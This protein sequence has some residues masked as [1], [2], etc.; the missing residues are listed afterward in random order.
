MAFI[1]CRI[2]KIFVEDN[3]EEVSFVSLSQ[4]SGFTPKALEKSKLETQKSAY[5]KSA[6][7]YKILAPK[8]GKIHLNTQLTKGMVLQA[9]NLLGSMA[10]TDEP[11]IIETL[12]SSDERP[13][14]H[15]GDE[16]SIAVAG[17][18]QAEYGTVEGQVEGIYGDATKIIRKGIYILKLG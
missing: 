3:I 1:Y 18:N 14:I 17:L 2:Y 4:S 8:S 11:L 9:G 7:E 16:V 15:T 12:L 5:D 6:D 13:R 10:S